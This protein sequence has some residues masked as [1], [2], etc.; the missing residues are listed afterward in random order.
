M[1]PFLHLPRLGR[2]FNP[3]GAACI[4]S[5]DGRLRVFLKGALLSVPGVPRPSAAIPFPV[6]F[7]SGAVAVAP[8]SPCCSPWMACCSWDGACQESEL[9]A[10]R[11]GPRQSGE[12]AILPQLSAWDLPSV[13]LGRQEV[14]GLSLPSW[15]ERVADGRGSRDQSQSWGIFVHTL[16]QPQTPPA[17]SQI[18]QLLWSLTRLEQSHLR[19]LWSSFT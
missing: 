19:Q 17:A 8:S 1:V 15:S 16:P 5:A 14:W 7:P 11:E 2:Q 6:A 3:F 12:Q 18:P 10:Y 9:H 13:V 4:A